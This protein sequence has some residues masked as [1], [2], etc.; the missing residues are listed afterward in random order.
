M[1]NWLEIK[2]E[3]ESWFNLFLNEHELEIHQQELNQF[4][5]ESLDLQ[6]ALHQH[7]EK[8]GDEIWLGFYHHDQ[9]YRRRHHL[10]IN[11]FIGSIDWRSNQNKI[12]RLAY[13][14]ASLIQLH[15]N[16]LDDQEAL[17]GLKHK[18]ADDEKNN[19]HFIL[20]Y[21]G[22][23]WQ[24]CAS[25]EYGTP[26]TPVQIENA[27]Y[28]IVSAQ[29]PPADLPFTAFSFAPEQ[30]FQ[31]I[32][33]FLRQ[34]RAETWLAVKEALFSVA[35]EELHND[36]LDTFGSVMSDLS[37]FFTFKPLNYHCNIT[38][39][40][41]YVHSDT[42]YCLPTEIDNWLESAQ[43]A[44]N[45]Q[46]F[47]RRNHLPAD[48]N[49]K[50]LSWN[51]NPEEAEQI[52]AHS[53]REQ[54]IIQSLTA[55]HCDLFLIEH[56]Q[57]LLE[58]SNKQAMMNLI[59]LYAQWRCD[60]QIKSTL[61]HCFRQTIVPIQLMSETVLNLL[62]ALQQHEENI[63]HLWADYLQ[64]YQHRSAFQPNPIQY[65]QALGCLARQKNK[66]LPLIDEQGLKRLNQAHL[67]I[68]YLSGEQ[69]LKNL[70]FMPSASDVF[71]VN[72]AIKRNN[73]HILISHH[74]NKVP[75][76]QRFIREVKYAS[77]QIMRLLAQH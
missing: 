21:R 9:Y 26:A 16:G 23:A 39:N 30:S 31:E 29:H 49:Q 43:M 44:F 42:A 55:T 46:G 50:A 47:P 13:F 73:I 1:Q 6:E 70:A 15:L 36:H 14:I 2:P 53:S 18:T 12:K 68:I 25:D 77:K 7:W 75:E 58:E 8:D 61:E 69:K 28:S 4:E 37:S 33:G 56:F 45:E 71:V 63:D 27:L 20:L 54:K 64:E 65:M 52:E 74:R 3:Y 17:R 67:H 32:K 62:E 34:N 35:L 19:R 10:L 24:F 48:L 41:F 57:A 72:Y 5:N 51:L 60:A 66:T 22:W 38:D 11:H 40:R 59:F 76:V